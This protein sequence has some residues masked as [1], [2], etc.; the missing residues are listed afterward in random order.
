MTYSAGDSGHV[1]VHNAIDATQASV[2]AAAAASAASAALSAS[3]VGAPADAAVAAV[4]GDPASDTATLLSATYG[5]YETPEKYG[6]VGDGT[7]DDTTAVNAAITAAMAVGGNGT[8]RLSDKT[9]K[10]LG[11]IA[12]P[13]TDTA[14]KAT[15]RPLRITGN[16]G[17]TT[18]GNWRTAPINGGPVLDLRY[19]GTDTLHPAKID[20]RGA[21]F[22][23]ID[24]IAISS[25]GTDDFPIFQTTNTT[26]HAHHNGIIGNPNKTGT[27]CVQVAFILGGVGDGTNGG[28]DSA[29]GPFQ[30]YGSTIHDNYFGHIQKGVLGQAFCNSVPIERNTFSTSCGSTTSGAIEFNGQG[31]ATG[32]AVGNST[33]GNTIEVVNYKY[34]ISAYN[35]TNSNFGPDGFWDATANTTAA[36]FLDTTAL[37]N[38]IVDG[39]RSDTKPFVIDLSGTSDVLTSHGSQESIHTARHTFRSDTRFSQSFGYGAASMDTQGDI[40]YLSVAVGNNPYPITS[41]GA[42][43]CTQFADGVTTSGS[44]AVTSATATFVAGDKGL[45]ISGTGI[46]AYSFI[47][48]VDS[49]TQVTITKAA[50]ATGSG[51]LLSVGRLGAGAN[52]ISFTRRHILGV[53]TAPTASVA[54][55]TNPA[56]GTGASV[57]VTGTDLAM[58]VSVT[59]GTTPATGQLFDSAP[60]IN[61]TAL[62]KIGVTAKSAAAGAFLAAGGYF[63]T[64]STGHVQAVAA[65]APTAGAVLTFDIVSIQ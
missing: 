30:G 55:G 61:F 21:G 42:K 48:R 60:N 8:V 17:S 46:P 36:I 5:A 49:A 58:N 23:E 16:G 25:G 10:C 37:N 11:A 1:A 24:H 3:L 32:Y 57:T 19:D 4:V 29:T 39:Y 52:E 27:A 40:G 26:V 54:V 62:T 22:L 64:T 20:T 18:D 41:V 35:V 9:Y 6:A 31:G 33:K 34:G 14:G 28:S 12:L 53:G 15:Q 51:I 2:I 43:P 63:I 44:R 56:A 65:V 7:T 13:F 45:A 59:I 47:E 50:T 38:R